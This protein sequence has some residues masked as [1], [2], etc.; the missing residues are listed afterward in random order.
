[1][2]ELNYLTSLY[3]YYKDLLTNKQRDYFE[4]YYFEN[5]LM[6]EIAENNGVSKN[7]VSKSLIEVK[8]KLEEYEKSL[9]LYYNKNKILSILDE[10]SCK[11]ISD[12]I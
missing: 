11:K 6:D 7:A 12:Y 8:E 5:L 9:N 3:D 10:E 4:E 2:N 1:M